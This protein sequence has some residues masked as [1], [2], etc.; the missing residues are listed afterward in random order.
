MLKRT[1]CCTDS[2]F[3]QKPHVDCSPSQKSA[4]AIQFL[5]TTSANIILGNKSSKQRLDDFRIADVIQHYTATQLEK[6]IVTRGA[7]HHPCTLKYT[8]LQNTHVIILFAHIYYLQ[9]V[10]Y[11]ICTSNYHLKYDFFL[12]IT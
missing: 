3:L 4:F 12:N 6:N 1:Y 5:S 7:T 10:L 9:H 2:R 8:H 11:I